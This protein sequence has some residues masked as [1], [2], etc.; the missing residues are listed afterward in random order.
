MQSILLNP[1][2]EENS[3]SRSTDVTFKLST[4][5]IIHHSEK[6]SAEEHLAIYRRS[7]LARLRS[8][9]AQQFSALEYA[10]GEELFR[11]FADDYLVQH[12]SSHYNL[13]LLG[14]HFPVHL[15]NTRPDV[16]QEKKEDWIDFM[17]ELAIFEYQVHQLFE[18][19]ADEN[20]Q[21]ATSQDPEETLVLLPVCSLFKFRFPIRAFYTAFKNGERPEL[22][23]ENESCCIVLRQQYKLVIYDLQAEQ[24]EFL[25]DLKTGMNV[26]VAKE[27]FRK[28]NSIDTKDFEQIWSVWKQRWIEAN[29]FATTP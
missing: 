4:E 18:Q 16:D 6:L 8:C 27:T 7:Y 13:S 12:P 9:M 28:R 29:F 11:A 26:P 10:L 20:Y 23:F 1:F 3:M 21:T 19:R 17:I 5:D 24:H 2:Q 15:E 22:P 14:L 25:V